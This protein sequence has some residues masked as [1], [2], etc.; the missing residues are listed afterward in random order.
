[1]TSV[2]SA[3]SSTSVSSDNSDTDVDLGISGILLD[4]DG[5]EV[6]NLRE[7]PEEMQSKEK[8]RK[9]SKRSMLSGFCQVMRYI[10]RCDRT[11]DII[12]LI[13][14]LGVEGLDDAEDIERNIKKAWLSVCLLARYREAR[15][16]ADIEDIWTE[17]ERSEEGLDNDWV[18]DDIFQRKERF[19]E[20]YREW[21]DRKEEREKEERKREPSRSRE[22]R[23]FEEKNDKREHVAVDE[24]TFSMKMEGNFGR[25]LD[26]KDVLTGQRCFLTYPGKLNSKSIESMV[27]KNGFYHYNTIIAYDKGR[28][29]ELLTK[30]YVDMRP[31]QQD[32]EK[33]VEGE[34]KR[35]NIKG[36]LIKTNFDIDNKHP[37]IRLV[38]KRNM[39][40]NVKDY[41]GKLN[42]KKY[43]LYV[44]P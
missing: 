8:E 1:M 30:V 20:E 22:S 27:E 23:N 43:P 13:S 10:Q 12:E 31:N 40:I 44:P 17:V 4:K 26:E 41:L 16:K 33:V 14:I 42:G 9:N 2:D 35:N 5:K 18:E 28:S 32:K 7:F 19:N 37:L 25:V 38:T 3:F 15:N 39:E 6:R 24:D 36:R 29:G 11:D 34:E 21:M